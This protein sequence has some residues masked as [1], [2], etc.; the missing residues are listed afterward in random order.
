MA[1]RNLQRNAANEKQ[2]RYADRKTTEREARF[3][4]SLAAVLETREGRIVIW[5][6]LT[7]AGIYRSIWDPSARIHYN[8]GRQDYGHEL[9]EAAI[10]AHEDGYLLMER[11]QRAWARAD[12]K[13]AAAVQT[14]AAEDDREE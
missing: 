9:L 1:R 13:E 8:A 10:E 7:R 4:D 11:E 6:L 3:H 14:P 5:E 2:V 12:D